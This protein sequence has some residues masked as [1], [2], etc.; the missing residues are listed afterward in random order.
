MADNVQKTPFAYSINR[1]GAKKARDAISILG[2]SLPASVVSV[3]GSIVKI[4]FEL[5]SPFTLPQIVVPLWGP[6]YIRYPTQ[7]G[8]KGFVIPAD[9]YLGGMSGLGGGIADL[10]LLANLSA[11]VF[12]PIGN[13][14][15]TATDDPNATV[16][17]GPN[18]VVLRTQDS[19]VKIVLTPSGIAITGDVTITGKLSTSDESDLAGGS[20]L[21]VLDGDPVSGGAVHSSATKTKAT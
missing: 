5:T 2:K 17:Y 4:K 12:V 6:E 15:W 7:V 21:V 19:S 14:N 11:L 8:D 10:A 13:S 1:F 20:K 3:T 18:G 16:I 9:A